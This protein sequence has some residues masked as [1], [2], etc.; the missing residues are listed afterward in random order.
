MRATPRLVAAAAVA[1][2]SAVASLFVPLWRDLWWTPLAA[3]SLAVALDAAFALARPRLAV[4]R[5]A[6]EAMVQGKSSTVGLRIARPWPRARVR[7]FDGIPSDFEAEG[8]PLEFDARA[9]RA[10]DCAIALKYAVRPMVRGIREWERGWAEVEGPLGLLARRERIAG[11]GI[12]RVYPDTGAYL[13]GGFRLPGERGNTAAYRKS[14]RRGHGLEFEQL[15]EYRRGD[16][17]RLIDGAASSRLRRPI[18]REMRDEEDQTVVFLLDTGYRMTAVEGGKSHFDRAFESMLALARVALRQGDRVGVLAWGPVQRW[19]P[20]RRGRDAFTGIV[21]ALYDIHA[22]PSASSPTLAVQ[23]LLPRLR[24]RSLIILLTNFREEDDEDMA[25]ILSAARS[26]HLI[27]TV[28]MREIEVAAAAARLP[29]DVD[30][31]LETAMALD[32]LDQRAK[33]RR[34]WELS[35]VLTL[36]T[37]PDQLGPSLIQRYWDIK[38]RGSL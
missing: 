23:D 3:A 25:R 30:E 24:R 38:K 9:A 21:N 4:S 1:L 20:P 14:R 18:V 26:R 8:L 34:R 16:P 37:T 13:A 2:A 29:A 32:Y 27:L 28:W 36:D 15:R 7:I 12:L 19:I 11:G 35:G 33:C 6:P 31:A 10:G 17:P 5:D 22:Q